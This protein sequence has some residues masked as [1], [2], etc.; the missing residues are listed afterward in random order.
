MLE[1]AAAGSHEW[2][3]VWIPHLGF[4]HHTKSQ[5]SARR[6]VTQYQRVFV[7]NNSLTRSLNK[8][9]VQVKRDDRDGKAP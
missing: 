9:G 6:R 3:P 5:E 2:P 4:L 1:G 7:W 8:F